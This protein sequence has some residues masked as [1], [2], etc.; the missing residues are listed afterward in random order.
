MQVPQEVEPE[1]LRTLIRSMTQID[2]D[3]RPS[4]RK[5]MASLQATYTELVERRDHPEYLM[6]VWGLP[7]APSAQPEP[8]AGNRGTLKDTADVAHNNAAGPPCAPRRPVQDSAQD[9]SGIMPEP[10]SAPK[11]P[12]PDVSGAVPEPP[13]ALQPPSQGTQPSRGASARAEAEDAAL[14]QAL[15]ESSPSDNPLV[16]ERSG[17]E[18]SP[19]DNAATHSA[20]NV[21]C[22]PLQDRSE[23]FHPRIPQPYSNAMLL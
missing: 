7:S 16:G 4:M 11:P 18:H 20:P 13:N 15:S 6:P 17:D 2:P 1:S 19:L 8:Q 23:C 12:A 3:A 10:P 21:R 9:Y 22:L 5:V 14:P